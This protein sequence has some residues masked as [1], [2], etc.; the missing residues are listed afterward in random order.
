[1][2]VGMSAEEEVLAVC[3]GPGSIAG[4]IIGTLLITLALAAAAALAYNIYWRSRK[5]WSLFIPVL[6]QPLLTHGI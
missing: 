2:E 4:A 6:N 3:Y 1:L 5:G